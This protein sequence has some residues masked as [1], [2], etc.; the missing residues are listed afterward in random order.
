MAKWGKGDQKVGVYNGQYHEDQLWRFQPEGDYYRI[1]N[2]SYPSAKIA[3]W[4]KPGEHMLVLIM[5][6]SYG[7]LF[8]NLRQELENKWCGLVTIGNVTVG[9]ILSALLLF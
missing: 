3:K 1:Y 7:S 2:K 4:G 6:T 8:L 9:Y 5:T